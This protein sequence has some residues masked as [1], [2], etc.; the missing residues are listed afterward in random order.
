[1]HTCVAIEDLGRA[2]EGVAVDHIQ[3]TRTNIQLSLTLRHRQLVERRS[4]SMSGRR[5]ID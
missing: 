4:K 5:H 1:M 3:C 2:V